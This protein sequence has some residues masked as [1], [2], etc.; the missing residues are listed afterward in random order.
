VIAVLE[1]VLADQNHAAV[2]AGLL[3]AIMVAAP[4]EPVTFVSTP[5]HRAAVIE[6]LGTEKT[7]PGRLDIDLLPPG[8]ICVARIAAQ[9]RVMREAVR[10]LRPRALV[11]LSSTPETFFACRLLSLTARGLRIVVVLHGNLDDAAGRRSRDPRHRLLDSRSSL[12]VGR[13][14]PI[15]FVVLEGSIREAAL[16]KG[17]LPADRTDVWPHPINDNEARPP[18]ER[19]LSGRISIAFVGAAKRSK[20]FGQFL[21]LARQARQHCPDGYDFSLIGTL[22]DRFTAEETA[23]LTLADTMLP[24]NEYLARLRNVDYA[25]LPLRSDT[26]TLTASG[27]LIDCIASTTPLIATRTAAVE[28][29]SRGGPIGF[30]GDTPEAL[31][32]IVMDRGRLG[33]RAGHALLQRNLAVLQQERRPAGIAR[34][35]RATLDDGRA[36]V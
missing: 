27:S 1:L 3:E 25:C 32:D 13:H 21:D 35:V 12:Y 31:A 8:G 28:H 36:E 33:D 7:A 14:S 18:R 22:Y 11:C 17:L 23:G 30:L 16:A 2:N 4:G 20:G 15:R 29:L 34:A 26:Y 9:F 24:R 6:T 10:T 5:K 19:P